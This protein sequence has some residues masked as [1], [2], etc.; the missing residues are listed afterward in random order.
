MRSRFQYLL[1]KIVVDGAN[2]TFLKAKRRSEPTFYSHRQSRQQQKAQKSTTATSDLDHDFESRDSYNVS[3]TL[4]G[5]DACSKV[6]I[7][8]MGIINPTTI[9]RNM[10]YQEIFEHEQANNEGVVAKAE[11][12]DA[13]AM[14][15]GKF[16]GRSPKDKYVV[17]N[18]GSQSAENM[19]WN[20]IK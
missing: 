6:G 5:T 11:Y 7:D 19:D 1:I 13:F 12:G 10:T 17:Y 4:V 14:S 9:Y 18:P 15:T 20:D 2:Y 16:T 8:K 3:Q